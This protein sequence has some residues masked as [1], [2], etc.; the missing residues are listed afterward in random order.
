MFNPKASVLNLPGNYASAYNQ[1]S[2][3][4]IG[5]AMNTRL[6]ESQWDTMEARG[7][8]PKDFGLRG[9]RLEAYGRL[10]SILAGDD[11][12]SLGGFGDLGGSSPGDVGPL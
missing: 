9:N 10:G 7:F 4:R 12:D 6:N 8:N 1:L 2:Y 5:D 11:D 3:G